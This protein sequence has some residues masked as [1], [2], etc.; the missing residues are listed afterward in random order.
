MSG[1]FAIGSGDLFWAVDKLGHFIGG[2]GADLAMAPINALA[3]EVVNGVGDMLA[4]L[5]TTWLTLGIPD[6]W[7]GGT[8]SGTVQYLH[9]EV[10]YLAG[11]LA[12]LGLMIG[13]ARLAWTQRAGIG[14]ELVEGLIL[15]VL[16]TGCGVPVIG[17]LTSAADEWSQS[18]ITNAVHGGDFGRNIGEMLKLSGPALAPILAIL[19]G[20]FALGVSAVMICELAFRAGMLVLLAGWL[21]VVAS[22]AVLPGGKHH[23]KRYGGWVIGLVMWKPVAALIYAAAFRLIGAH[24]L[25]SNGIG[26]ILIGLTLM[27]AAVWALPALVQFLTPTVDAVPSRPH[28]ETA[29]RAAAIRAAAGP[30]GA[31]AVPSNHPA[32]GGGMAAQTQQGPSGTRNGRLASWELEEHPSVKSPPQPAPRPPRTPPADNGRP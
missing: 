25:D 11:F 27:F 29:V 22:M 26:S 15:M 14:F 12:V 9:S 10:A 16:I 17:L 13:G 6:I 28:P 5:G 1:L 19:F 31:K 20:L 30:T 7:H 23:A 8:T 4:T 32:W 2:A 24:E 21:P 18:I 3:S